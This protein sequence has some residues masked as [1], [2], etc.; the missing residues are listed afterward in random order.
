MVSPALEHAI[1]MLNYHIQ[2]SQFDPEKHLKDREQQYCQLALLGAADC[3]LIRET[4][5]GWWRESVDLKSCET[6]QKY[7][8]DPTAACAWLMTPRFTELGG[9]ADPNG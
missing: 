2:L 8:D 6:M 4:E 9:W 3:F 7:I 1:E 5:D